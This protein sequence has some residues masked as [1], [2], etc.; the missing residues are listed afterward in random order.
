[1]FGINFVKFRTQPPAT[2]WVRCKANTTSTSTLSGVKFS[3]IW[4][5]TRIQLNLR[6]AQLSPNIFSCIYLFYWRVDECNEFRDKDNDKESEKKMS[7]KFANITCLHLIILVS[8]I[9][10]NTNIAAALSS[11]SKLFESKSFERF[12][13][14]VVS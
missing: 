7:I 5:K 12:Q 11:L 14:A 10:R 8:H 3:I 1:M 9:K 4:N 2:S 6:F 13:A